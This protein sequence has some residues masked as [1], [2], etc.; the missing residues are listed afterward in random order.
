[1]MLLVGLAGLT[2]AARLR[3]NKVSEKA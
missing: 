2:G 1:M 3:K